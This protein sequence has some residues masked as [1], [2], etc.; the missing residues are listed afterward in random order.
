M[1][2]RLLYYYGEGHG[3]D[4]PLKNIDAMKET[5][6]WFKKYKNKES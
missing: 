3:F 4:D 6:S 5:I 2:T 1:P